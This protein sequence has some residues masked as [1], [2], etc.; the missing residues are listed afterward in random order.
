MRAALR[1]AAFAAGLVL[2]WGLVAQSTADPLKVDPEDRSI[3]SRNALRPDSMLTEART[4][5]QLGTL[6]KAE[7]MVRQY[8]R[9]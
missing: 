4:L 9:E 5:V 1:T 8:L 7:E 3:S 2:P 6:N